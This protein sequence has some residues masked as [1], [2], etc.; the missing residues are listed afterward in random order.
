MAEVL[1]IIG[2]VAVLLCAPLLTGAAPMRRLTAGLPVDRVS[3]ILIAWAVGVSLWGWCAWLGFVLK[4]PLAVA[5]IVFIIAA[6]VAIVLTIKTPAGPADH[7]HERSDLWLLIIFV[8]VAI[9]FGFVGAYQEPPSDSF[10]HLGF[11]R[12][13]QHQPV[14]SSTA[15]EVS[16]GAELRVSNGNYVYNT[17][18]AGFAAIGLSTSVDAPEFWQRTPFVLIPLSLAMFWRVARMFGGSTAAALT[19]MS[20]WM[21]IWASWGNSLR[22]SPYPR[23]IAWIVY[24]ALVLLLWLDRRDGNRGRLRFW[25][26][27]AMLA[28]LFSFHVQIGVFGFLTAGALMLTEWIFRGRSALRYLGLLLAGIALALPVLLPVFDYYRQGT[29]G[30]AIADAN[31]INPL[32]VKLGDWVLFNPGALTPAM[33]AGILLAIGFAIRALRR[34]SEAEPATL[35]MSIVIIGTAAAAFLPPVATLVAKFGAPLLLVRLAELIRFWA[36]PL[37]AVTLVTWW[38]TRSAPLTRIPWKTAAAAVALAALA[39]EPVLHLKFIREPWLVA[40]IA[41]VIAIICLIILPALLRRPIAKRLAEPTLAGLAA[42]LLIAVLV[43]PQSKLSPAFQLARDAGLRTYCGPDIDTVRASP[44]LRTMLSHIGEG[45]VVI[46]DGAHDEVVLVYTDCLI[47]GPLKNVNGMENKAA[48]AE[49]TVLE[50]RASSAEVL[51]ALETLEAD[52]LLLSPFNASLAWM[53]FD[54]MPRAF[55]PVFRSR[56]SRLPMYQGDY[57][58]Y[59]IHRQWLRVALNTDRTLDLP[60]GG[61]SGQALKPRIFMNPE[62]AASRDR[63]RKVLQDGDLAS[64]A[65]WRLPASPVWAYLDLQMRQPRQLTGFAV[66]RAPSGKPPQG[67]ALYVRDPGKRWRRVALSAEGFTGDNTVWRIDL[68][69]IESHRLRLAFEGSGLVTLGDIELTAEHLR[70]D[71]TQP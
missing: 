54:N 53:R 47:A 31:V 49:K 16:R 36:V 22:G 50:A 63:A 34:R 9:A 55:E 41:L 28:I 44:A 6:A 57:R 35:F 62:P 64:F 33:A 13:L 17:I 10:R 68:T 27:A 58:L 56:I 11:I 19:A 25:V 40:A 26:I 38:R 3:M 20:G 43:L 2:A 8:I 65:A 4:L 24:G 21:L 39:I 42:L 48:R 66:H 12:R 71:A 14:M 1:L 29:G 46:A 15:Y 52:Y 37:A 51:A 23:N 32:I 5:G 30:E 45:D 18:H 70:P 67:L 7:P 61:G 60:A 59:R 69:G